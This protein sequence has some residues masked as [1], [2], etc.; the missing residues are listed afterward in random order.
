MSLSHDQEG[1]PENFGRLKR[2]KI[3]DGDALAGGSPTAAQT[4]GRSTSSLVHTYS[5]IN[6]GA[7]G[8]NRTGFEGEEE[9]RVGIQLNI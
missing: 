5:L 9:E 1:G 3:K 4:S 6:S 8:L 2:Y 7:H